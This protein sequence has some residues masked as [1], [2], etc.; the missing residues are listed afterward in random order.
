MSLHGILAF[1]VVIWCQLRPTAR[2]G[3]RSCAGLR[4]VTVLRLPPSRFLRA[5]LSTD[6]PTSGAARQTTRARSAS[7][8]P[9]RRAAAAPE[10]HGPQRLESRRRVARAPVLPARSQRTERA[11]QVPA[12]GAAPVHG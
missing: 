11:D 3:L 4:T 5:L 9:R 2:M 7:T 8:R 12:L 6:Q 1:L 10:R